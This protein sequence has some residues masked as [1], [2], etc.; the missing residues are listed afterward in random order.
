MQGLGV[1]TYRAVENLHVT[2]LCQN[3]TA[4]SLLLTRSLTDNTNSLL[5]NILCVICS[6]HYILTMK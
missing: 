3:L 2:L 1:L 5:A 4:N 6:I